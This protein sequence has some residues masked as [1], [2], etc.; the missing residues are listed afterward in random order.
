MA[1]IT[2]SPAPSKRRQWIMRLTYSWWY[3]KIK[4]RMRYLCGAPLEN[5]DTYTIV[6]STSGATTITFAEPPPPGA[7][8]VITRVEGL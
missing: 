3:P 1:E 5:A 8:I 4:D 7:V 2:L 6:D